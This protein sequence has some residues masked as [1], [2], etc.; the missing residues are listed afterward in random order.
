MNNFLLSNLFR[1]IF[2]RF[3]AVMALLSLCEMV[4][5]ASNPV[6]TV[7]PLNQQS[8]AASNKTAV[9]AVLNSQAKAIMNRL[10][11]VV[12][13]QR[14]VYEK[15]AAL[16]A[17]KN[18]QAKALQVLQHRIG[19]KLQ[20]KGI[21]ESGIP[22]QIKGGVLEAR[23]AQSGSA[24]ERDKKVAQRFLNNQK[25]LLGL[26][27]PSEEMQF[28]RYD[29]DELGRRHLRYQQM[30]QGLPVWPAEAVVHIDAQGNVDAFDGGHIK[31]PKKGTLDPVLNKSD[32]L[33]NARKAVPGSEKTQAKEI[34]LIMYAPKNQEPRLAWKMILPVSTSENWLVVIDALNG[35]TLTAFN[36]VTD[37]NVNGSGADLLG[38]N[39]PLNVWQENGSYWMVDTS[40]AMFDTSVNPLSGSKGVIQVGD[41]RNMPPTS[42][43]QNSPE[44]EIFR[45]ASPDASSGWVPDAVS[46]A[47]NLSETYDYYLERHKRNSF[48]NNGATITAIVRYGKNYQNAFWN[49]SLMVF[50]DSDR[51]AASLDVVAH[52]LSHAVTQY[53]ADLVY[54]NQ[55]GALNEAFSD[56]L[57]ESVEARSRGV[58]DWLLGSDMSRQIRSM[59]DPSLFDDPSKMSQFL[60]TTQDNGGVHTNSNIINHAYYLLVEG[61]NGGIGIQDAERI[62]YRAL[63]VHLLK[64][65]EFVDARRAAILSA[66]EIFGAGS[67]QAQR[68]AQAF[69]AVE[70]TDGGSTPTPAPIPTVSG[71]DSILSLYYSP[72]RDNWFLY[73]RE[74]A[75]GDPGIGTEL[76]STPAA[77]KRPS[78]T[79]DGEVGL[80][81][82]ASDDVCVFATNNVGSD[83]CLGYSGQIKSIA[84]APNGDLAALVMRDGNGNST[85]KVTV[86]DLN[87]TSN[88]RDLTLKT[89][90]TD[91]FSVEIEYADALSFTPDSRYLVFDALNEYTINGTKSSSWSIYALDLS[92]DHFLN[93]VN[94]IG[95]VD[96]AFPS[97]GH[98]RSDLLTFEAK[99]QTTNV[100]TVY[101]ANLSNGDTVKVGQIDSGYAVP[102]FNG[103]DSTILYSRP[104]SSM[105]S[106]SSLY[107]QK[108][109]SDHITPAGSTE[110]SLEDADFGVFYRRGTF[111][112]ANS[113]DLRVDATYGKVS[114][115]PSGAVCDNQICTARFPQNT[116]VTMIADPIAGWNFDHWVG[117]DRIGGSSC[118]VTMNGAK[119]V[120]AWFTSNENWTL[121][122]INSKRSKKSG[123]ITS[124]PAGINCKLTL[125]GS[126]RKPVQSGACSALF[127]GGS[128]VT[129]S[130][131]PKTGL[132]MDADPSGCDSGGGQNCTVS[133]RFPQTQATMGLVYSS[134]S[135]TVN[136]EGDGKITGGGINC[137]KKCLKTYSKSKVTKVRLRAKPARGWQ[138]SGWDGC[139]S[140]KGLSCS[141]T[142]HSARS[143]RAVFGSL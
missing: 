125:K 14:A 33:I 111:V 136:K 51:W 69:D 59:K 22:K 27:K 10:G 138:L 114:I 90:A 134:K 79:G 105:N 29:K 77:Y 68:T 34:V 26:A 71:E 61:L 102:G 141:V 39:R 52:E 106:G 73:R 113:V 49:G 13:Q 16:T 137:G 4:M 25:A 30:H 3:I 89:P 57:G 86:L 103:D 6:I 12:T 92:S 43:P 139:D 2:I 94:V 19:Q 121:S 54:Q 91:G 75:L 58:N 115:S 88:S 17:S 135:L 11:E 117:C 60:V 84:I 140:S 20:V 142:V 112:G 100:S 15:N 119:N 38:N 123:T 99:D 82:S 95:G 127:P 78:V 7:N 107:V 47:F 21:E 37:A 116:A 46:A 1:V 45:V 87:N 64:N 132:M 97:A 70:I 5:A 96:V 44:P 55:S 110:F 83:S 40:K 120:E 122:V 74:N 93:V 18:A 129:L 63:T 65:S 128:I 50:G 126:K 85:N 80:F 66:E 67:L 101:T 56:I 108:L 48:D 124:N 109:A 23:I 130:I 81:V 36:Q 143:V 41:T 8:A 53:S 31:T 32:A 104:D 28:N 76:T 62:F 131:D 9:R 133:V 98:T 118:S 35:A 24:Q 42:D 72:S